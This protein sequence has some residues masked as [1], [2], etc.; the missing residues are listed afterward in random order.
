MNRM[1]DKITDKCGDYAKGNY[2]GW[3]GHCERRGECA[4]KSPHRLP[5][6]NSAM[7]VALETKSVIKQYGCICGQLIRKA[8]GI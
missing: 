2:N 6:S 5:L 3:A 1:I 8:D 7:A 4:N